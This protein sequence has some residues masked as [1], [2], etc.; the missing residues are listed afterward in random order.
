[1]AQEIE[2]WAVWTLL[3][4]GLL[5]HNL[6]SMNVL[7]VDWWP[8]G[9]WGTFWLFMLPIGP[10]KVAGILFGRDA[11]LGAL[12]IYGLYVLKDLAAACYVEP[13]VRLAMRI[14]P[15]YAWARSLGP[16][17]RALAERT[18]LGEGRP[19]QM[20]SLALVSMG[21]GFMT[22]GAALPSAKVA[23]PLGWVGIILGDA[24]WFAAVL[25]TTLGLAS[26]LPDDRMV[27]GAVV[28][29]WLVVRPL[30]KRLTPAPVPTPAAD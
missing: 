3:A 1:M 26:F 29:L 19:A 23:R 11:G 9:G 10:T 21:A 6:P 16:Q 17:V 14:G 12:A 15:R 5:W 4:R 8:A 18:H 7:S 24:V 30:M 20:L 25:A 13:L 27:F 28:I 2:P 22:A